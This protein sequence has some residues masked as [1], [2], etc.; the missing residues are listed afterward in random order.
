MQKKRLG[1][2]IMFGL[3]TVLGGCQV[4][5]TPG[6]GRAAQDQVQRQTAATARTETEQGRWHLEEQ[7]N[8]LA[9]EAFNR[10]LAFGEA[11]GPAL[12]GLG[13]AFARL[14]RAD[15]AYRFFSQAMRADPGN[16]EFARN[17]T[18]LSRSNGFT[19]AAIRP[20][21]AVASAPV[22]QPDPRPGRIRLHR[23]SNRQVALTTLPVAW[24]GANCAVSSRRAK[25]DACDATK[26]P[27]VTAQNRDRDL[28]QAMAA[29][30]PEQ[31]KA[32]ARKIVTIG[33]ADRVPVTVGAKS[34]AGSQRQ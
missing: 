14:G 18:I 22:K 3:A 20:V 12:N 9:I 32:D 10:A 24:P 27:V 5:R 26:L 11:P 31:V 34:T 4:I 16:P 29:E 19:L 28:R 21:P 13:V 30:R 17:L 1:G 33:F 23:E 25:S 8:G 6:L 7:R 15:L 2:I